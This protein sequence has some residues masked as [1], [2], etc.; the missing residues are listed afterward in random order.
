MGAWLFR[1][2]HVS[3]THL[4]ARPYGL[5]EREKDFYEAFRW[6]VDR[7]LELRVDAVLHAGDMFHSS[8][9]RPVTY[10]HAIRELRRLTGAGVRFIVAP[11]NHELPKAEA[12]GSPIRVLE[13]LGLAYAPR[14]PGR[15]HA[16]EFEGLSVIVFSEWA[17]EHLSRVDPASLTRSKVRVGLAHVT[18]CDALAEA[19]GVPLERCGGPRRML[20]SMVRGGYSYLA[21]GDIHTPWEHRVPGAP[22]MV[23]PGSTEYLDVDEYRRNSSRYVYLVELDEGGLVRAERLKIETVRPWIVVEGGYQEVSR[24][25]ESVRRPPGSKEPIVY[26]KVKGTLDQARRRSLKARLDALRG[27]GVI[28]HYDLVVEERGEPRRV[29]TPQTL[30]LESMLEKLLERCGEG[31]RRDLVHLLT[32][33]LNNPGDRA[34]VSSFARALEERGDLVECINRAFG[35]GFPR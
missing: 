33:L 24:I 12:L 2:I 15:P 29:Y 19:E 20:S 13:D 30:S 31:I 23:Y 3:D 27:D 17:S 26:V 11:G 1:F 10:I 28:L 32:M 35:E 25:I 8:T 18:L 7:A 16:V 4:G 34:V 6:V 22:P 5:I 9:P 14:D 21:L